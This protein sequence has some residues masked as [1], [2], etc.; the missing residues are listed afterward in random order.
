[1]ILYKEFTFDSAHFLPLVPAGHK[2]SGMHG[3]TYRL[4]VF[5]SGEVQPDTGWVLDYHDLKKAVEPVIGQVD[6][7]LLN[8]VPGLDNPTSEVLAAWLWDRIK[9]HLPLLSRIELKE[10]PSSGVIYEGNG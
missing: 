5:A 4:T 10:T 1:M 3:H 7:R 9:P 8:E 2:C 6:H